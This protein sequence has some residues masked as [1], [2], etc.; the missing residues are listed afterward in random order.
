[1]LNKIPPYKNLGMLFDC[2]DCYD[3]WNLNYNSIDKLLDDM[4]RLTTNMHYYIS[5]LKCVMNECAR[6]PINLT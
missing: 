3:Y 2:D 1:M 6:H 4:D 5:S